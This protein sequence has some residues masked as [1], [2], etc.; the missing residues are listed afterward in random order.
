MRAAEKSER[1]E[2][3][4]LRITMQYHSRKGTVYEL[5]KA[6]LTLDV[7]VAP[8]QTGESLN[9]PDQWL[10]GAQSSRA[11]DAVVIAERAGTRTEALRRVGQTWTAC[12]RERNLP[13]FDWSAVEKV[14]LSVRAL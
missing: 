14:L 10:V 5:E 1:A 12:A 7:H 6:G 3:N 9:V 8:D 2:P 13:L 11:T 4:A